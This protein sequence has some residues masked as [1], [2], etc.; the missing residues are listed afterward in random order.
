MGTSMIDVERRPATTAV[1]RTR[2]ATA[3]AARPRLATATTARH[4]LATTTVVHNPAAIVTLRLVKC[5]A[6][7]LRHVAMPAWTASR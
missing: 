6:G 5:A 4:G 2:L 3:T 1:T 7:Q